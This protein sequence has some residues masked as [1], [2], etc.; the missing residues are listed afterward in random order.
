MLWASR[1]VPVRAAVCFAAGG[2]NPLKGYGKFTFPYMII[3]VISTAVSAQ[4]LFP[5]Y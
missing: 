3:A 1:P 2:Y 4:I 5:L